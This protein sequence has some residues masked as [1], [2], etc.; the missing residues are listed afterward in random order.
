[1]ERPTTFKVTF[2]LCNYE[3]EMN[4]HAKDPKDVWQKTIESATPTVLTK[5]WT[6]LEHY[7]NVLKAM[8]G[9]YIKFY[10]LLLKI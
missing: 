6:E 1:M 5:L 3:S 8:E 10:L 2:F 9:V 4:D 7:I